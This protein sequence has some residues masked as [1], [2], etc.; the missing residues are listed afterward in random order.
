MPKKFKNAELQDLADVLTEG[1]EI[2]NQDIET[3][4]DVVEKLER[5]IAEIE[6]KIIDIEFGQQ[7]AAPTEDEESEMLQ[8]YSEFVPLHAFSSEGDITDFDAQEEFVDVVQVYRGQFKTS[9]YWTDTF[10][11]SID[12]A[13]E[14]FPGT[15]YRLVKMSRADSP[16]AEET[17][18][19]T[20]GPF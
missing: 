14:S 9:E 15:K 1:M 11:R 4:S 7:P 18:D 12:E 3:L 5:T 8:E 13:R 2:Q 6:Q 19:D 20:L 17:D 16:F 10:W